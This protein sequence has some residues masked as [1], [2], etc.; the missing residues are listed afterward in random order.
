MSDQLA[1]QII[2]NYVASTLAL[3]ASS[4]VPATEAARGINAYRSERLD[5]FIRWENAKFSLQELPTEYKLQAI[6]AI[7]QITA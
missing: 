3:R 2:D 7:E 5:I 1:R 4:S 6:E